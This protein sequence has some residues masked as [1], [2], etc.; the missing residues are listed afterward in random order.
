VGAVGTQGFGNAL[1]SLVGAGSTVIVSANGNAFITLSSTGVIKP[2]V[3][4]TALLV[5]LGSGSGSGATQVIVHFTGIPYTSFNAS[6]NTSFVTNNIYA[7]FQELSPSAS[8]ASND[9][10]TSFQTQPAYS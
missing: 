7:A 8:Y 6:V 3:S 4:F 5:L 2:V 1:V 9:P 10:Y